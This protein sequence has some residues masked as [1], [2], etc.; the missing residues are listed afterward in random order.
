MA[1]RLYILNNSK[2][3]PFQIEEEVTA[4]EETRLRHRYLDLRRPRPHRNIELRHR[5]LFEMR[6][7]LDSLGFFEIETP[8]LTRS[9]PEGARDYLVPSRVH[10]GQFYALPQSPQI[11]KQILMI[12]G[13]DR[14]FQIARCFRDE[15]LRA[16]RQP[17]FTQIDLEMT[18]P[19]QE[20]IFR[21]VEGFLT[22]AFKTSG[23]SLTT[24]FVQMTYDDAIKN[25]GIDKPDMRLPAM[26]SLTDELTA[27][28]RETLKI[29]KVLPVLGFVIPRAGGLSGTQ[30]RALVEEIR[31]AFGDSGLDFLDVARLKTKDAFA[32]LASV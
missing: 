8:M 18:F 17:E 27:E 22:A 25:Y 16:D 19:Q 2:T 11:F 29:E 1:T 4:S 32:P 7:T 28:L 5:I 31:A 20:T 6:K 26:V 23:I 9:T 10:H 15:D 12:S 24:P 14:Y 13:M 21:V 30:K 3:P